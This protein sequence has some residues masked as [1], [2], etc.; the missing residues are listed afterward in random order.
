MNETGFCPQETHGPDGRLVWKQTRRK[1]KGP[2][3]QKLLLF[4]LLSRNVV[5]FI[6]GKWFF[7]GENTA[8]GPLGEK[9]MA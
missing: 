3:I 6:L 2:F 4:F 1:T 9:A 7:C 5:Y 8:M